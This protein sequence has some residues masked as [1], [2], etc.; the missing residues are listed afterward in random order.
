MSADIGLRQ[1]SSR[2]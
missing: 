2:R 1:A